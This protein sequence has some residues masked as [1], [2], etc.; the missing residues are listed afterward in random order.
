M[1]RTFEVKTALFNFPK[2]SDPRDES[3]ISLVRRHYAEVFDTEK[4]EASYGKG[5]NGEPLLD[6]IYVSAEFTPEKMVS[7]ASL[8]KEQAELL[9]QIIKTLAEDG[10]AKEDLQKL[11]DSSKD[12]KP[13]KKDDKEDKDDPLKDMPEIDGEMGEKDFKDEMPPDPSK[14]RLPLAVRRRRNLSAS[15]LSRQYGMTFKAAQSVVADANRL[16]TFP[17]F[18]KEASRKITDENDRPLPRGEYVR[19]ASIA[20]GEKAPLG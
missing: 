15:R 6:R 3:N 8:D 4:V 12:G 7:T 1:K 17:Q 19:I 13:D 2:G 14:P 20:R 9:G 5:V 11:M 18:H 10:D 16:K